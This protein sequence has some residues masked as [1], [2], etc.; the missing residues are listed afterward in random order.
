MVLADHS[1]DEWTAVWW[2]WGVGVA[3]LLHPGDPEAAHARRLLA[4]RYP[5]YRDAPPPGMVIAVDVTRWSGWAG[6]AG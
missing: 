4:A 1:V 2:A 3:R 5:Q 6:A